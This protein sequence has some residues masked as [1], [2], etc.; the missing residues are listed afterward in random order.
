MILDQPRALIAPP[1][2]ALPPP[3][4]GARAAEVYPGCAEP[5]P[6]GKVWYVDPVN[7]K[8]PADGGN[9]SKAAPWNSL[10]GVISVKPAGLHSPSALDRPVR[11]LR[12]SPRAS[13]STPRPELG[14]RPCSRA[15]KSC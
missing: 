4:G 1:F 15:T 14:S 11:P 8:T 5:G 6:I 9:G 7:G 10:Q 3:G 2:S 12:T 13:A